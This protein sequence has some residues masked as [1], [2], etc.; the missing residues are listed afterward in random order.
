MLEGFDDIVYTMRWNEK[1]MLDKGKQLNLFEQ[2]T[3]E[4]KALCNWLKENED[5][6]IDIIIKESGI[7]KS[8]IPALMECDKILLIIILN[9]LFINI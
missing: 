4:Q 5:C 2:L 1:E 6:T 9:A 3:D 7:E 8:K